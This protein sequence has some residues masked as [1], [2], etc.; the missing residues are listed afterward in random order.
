MP[1]KLKVAKET[2]PGKGPGIYL[3]GPYVTPRIHDAISQFMAANR[4]DDPRYIART[5]VTAFFQGGCDK[6]DGQFIF[7]ELLR[8]WES[9]DPADV[10]EFERL[11][12]EAIEGKVPTCQTEIRIAPNTQGAYY[13]ITEISKETGCSYNS[14]NAFTPVY[15]FPENNEQWWKVYNLCKEMGLT[16]GFPQF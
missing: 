15:F 9:L 2:L 11:L 14:G 13:F 1:F 5:K 16:I 7:L 12:N 3:Y 10:A 6:R 4:I 8:S